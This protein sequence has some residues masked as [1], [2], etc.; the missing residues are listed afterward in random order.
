M[1][2]FPGLR[3]GRHGHDTPLFIAKAQ[4]KVSL[5]TKLGNTKWLAPLA[6]A[7]TIDK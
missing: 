3:Q 2:I 6:R 1:P 4:S 5:I 7:N